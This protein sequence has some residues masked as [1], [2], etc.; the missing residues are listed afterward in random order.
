MGSS[1]STQAPGVVTVKARDIPPDRGDKS[2]V[3]KFTSKPLSSKPS[4]SNSTSNK[5]S[6]ESKTSS[7]NPTNEKTTS[8]SEN[9]SAS[10]KPDDKIKKEE[11]QPKVKGKDESKPQTSTTTKETPS[12]SKEV[13]K[14]TPNP[15]K[16]D[17]SKS[18][19]GE[20]TVDQ[21]KKPEGEKFTEKE[22]D[23][24]LKKNLELYK[25]TKNCWTN[26]DV[27]SSE[28]Q[29]HMHE[30]RLTYGSFSKFPYRIKFE[31][32]G[33]L[34]SPVI[35]TGTFGIACDVVV[36]LLEEKTYFTTDENGKR[37]MKKMLVRLLEDCLQTVVSF[38]DTAPK[39]RQFVV[40]KKTFLPL[41]V[42]KL[43]EWYTWYMDGTLQKE[44]EQKLVNRSLTSLFMI[45]A[46]EDR[47]HNDNLRIIDNFFTVV[48][49]YLVDN[50]LSPRNA[51]NR[52]TA[53]ATLAY[54]ATESE[55][56]GIATDKEVFRFLISELQQAFSKPHLNAPSGW[57]ITG[58]AKALKNLAR[59]DANKRLLVQEGAITFGEINI[60]YLSVLST[61]LKNL[62]RSDANKRLLVQEGALPVMFDGLK[63]K[64]QKSHNWA[65]RKCCMEAL[66][67]L[68]F[69]PKNREEIAKNEALLD[70]VVEIYKEGTTKDAKIFAAAEGFLFQMSDHIKSKAKYAD[71][72]LNLLGDKTKK[73]N[74]SDTEKSV[75]AGHIMMSYQTQYRPIVKSI[76][77]FLGEKGFTMW[78][79]IHNMA[80]GDESTLQTMAEAVEGSAVVLMC[81][82]ESYKNSPYCR[83]EAEYA[84]MKKKHIIPLKLQVG[85]APD[86][87]LGIVQGSKFFYDFTKETAVKQK[88][89]Q[90][91]D[92]VT[93]AVVAQA[94]DSTSADDKQ[95]SSAPTST[96]KQATPTSMEDKV[97]QWTKQ[98]VKKWMT[99]FNLTGEKVEVLTADEIL[100]LYNLKAESP[101]HF[102]SMVRDELKL[103]GL[104]SSVSFSKALDELPSFVSAHH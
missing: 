17:Q 94:G 2:E 16:N 29:E 18:K 40:D 67:F 13:K 36:K 28:F 7:S 59:S 22:A 15:E 6:T 57:T 19:S 30:V 44:N 39:T 68:S 38:N 33:K 21:S 69:E 81:V 84:F 91:L 72:A 5:P 60:R 73:K 26:C 103:T 88:K 20:K 80:D 54:V 92:A 1:T 75:D 96:A 79:D 95:K 23:V 56:Q 104:K 55:A 102:H 63:E 66:W 12:E 3:S 78:M 14:T 61:A 9:K 50:P 76:C 31:Y 45:A 24:I 41:L 74:A 10:A 77:D 98:D 49:K 37:E 27:T 64:F 25:K 32:R 101:E 47:K 87:W 35:D 93:K 42:K 97:K 52:L 4:T 100:Y 8:S 51:D 58:L 65:E 83:A 89:Q 48:R 46:Q 53:I 34:I 90:L 86:G 85:Y 70:M 43:D 82:S 99:S 62:A 71:I 11:G